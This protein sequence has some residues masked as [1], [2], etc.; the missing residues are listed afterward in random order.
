MVYGYQ[1]NVEGLKEFRR[2]MLASH[3]RM[4]IHRS[5]TAPEA[6][7]Q[8]IKDDRYCGEIYSS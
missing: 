5:E 4:K 7:H 8:G 1:G 3:L 6:A 2:H